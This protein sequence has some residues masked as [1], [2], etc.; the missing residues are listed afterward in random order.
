MQGGRNSCVCGY[1]GGKS[2][3]LT[4]VEG[5]TL[6]WS[7]RPWSANS[8]VRPKKSPTSAFGDVGLC[9]IHTADLKKKKKAKLLEEEKNK[10]KKE[11]WAGVVFQ[12]QSHSWQHLSLSLPKE[13][14]KR[15]DERVERKWTREKEQIVFLN[16][17]SLF[18]HCKVNMLTLSID[19]LQINFDLGSH[20]L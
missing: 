6:S 11:K 16:F 4:E 15:R 19:V 18:T 13:G 10:W 9:S 14:G 20:R 7:T 2:A 17:F 8:S 3:G 1:F 5:Y 12:K